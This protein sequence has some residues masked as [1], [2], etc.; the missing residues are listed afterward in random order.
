MLDKKQRHTRRIK[1]SRARI[2]TMQKRRPRLSVC[3]SNQHISAQIIIDGKVQACASTTSR[4]APM[5]L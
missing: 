3:R 2:D 4:C 1:R 5:S